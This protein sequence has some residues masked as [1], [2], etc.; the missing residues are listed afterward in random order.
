MRRNSNV[1]ARRQRGNHSPTISGR[2][3]AALLTGLLALA[4]AAR[5]DVLILDDGTRV[6]GK[7]SKDGDQWIVIDNSGHETDVPADRIV[8]FHL[9]SGQAGGTAAER[10]ATLR[11]SSAALSDLPTII[12]RFQKFIDQNPGTPEA[13]QAQSDLADWQK[14]LDENCVKVGRQWLTPSQ[15]DAMIASEAETAVKIGDLV[16]QH[17]MQDA[18]DA[19]TQAL[20]LDPA[21]PAALYLNGLVLA[22]AGNTADARAQFAAVNKT[23]PHHAPTLNNLGVLV[24]R[25]KFTPAALAS[26]TQAMQASPFN[27][28]VLDNV[29]EALHAVRK[30]ESDASPVIAAAQ[31]FVEEDRHLQKT[32]AA[33]GLYRWGSTWVTSAQLQELNIEEQ[34]IQQK[35]AVLQTDYDATQS[36]ITTDDATIAQDRQS[37]IALQ[38][39]QWVPQQPVFSGPTVNQQPMQVQQQPL[40]QAYYDDQAEI[41][42]L[43][44]SRQRSVRHLDEL[45]IHANK[46]KQEISTPMYTGL[47]RLIG[48]EGTPI[49]TGFGSPATEPAEG[50]Q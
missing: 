32:Q 43:T 18:A 3:R 30:D 13:E 28:I 5:A 11:S 38:Q 42:R 7:A 41:N 19:I 39:E 2:T 49:R 20:E 40:P 36:D 1:L 45:N 8:S 50:S 34:T 31:M 10:L 14:K 24:F 4:A 21:D 17:Q 46:I 15:R 23:V 27:R 47:L 29:A 35:L 44:D 26:F 12:H 9:G 37:M 48:P 25:Q 22:D 16:R 33:K 6:E